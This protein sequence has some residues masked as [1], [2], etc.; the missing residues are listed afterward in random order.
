MGLP[1]LESLQLYNSQVSSIA[2]E[3]LTYLTSLKTDLSLI[4][5]VHHFTRLKELRLTNIIRIG[6][7]YGI[8][9]EK[10]EEVQVNLQRVEE[11]LRWNQDT[12]ERVTLALIG[13]GEKM[14]RI[15]DLIKKIVKLS[16]LY[17]IIDAIS[18]EHIQ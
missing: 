12:L 14:Q 3:S 9:G 18:E 7:Q 4:S 1:S 13:V 5:S 15:V 2:L 11:I 6:Y 16:Y 8:S 17:L 10:E